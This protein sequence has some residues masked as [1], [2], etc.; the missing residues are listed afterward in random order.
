MSSSELQTNG[1][2]VYWSHDTERDTWPVYWTLIGGISDVYD[3]SYKF[4]T[5]LYLFL[6]IGTSD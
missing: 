3:F 5:V 2:A 6:E 1:S 4:D